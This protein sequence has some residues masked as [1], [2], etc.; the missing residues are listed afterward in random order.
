MGRFSHIKLLFV[1]FIAT[2]STFGALFEKP[3]DLSKADYDFIIVGGTC[4]APYI[5]TL[6]ILACLL[7]G[8]AGAVIANRLTENPNVSVLVLEAGNAYVGIDEIHSSLIQ[9]FSP[10]TLAL[11]LI[12][13]PSVHVSLLIRNMTGI[14]PPFRNLVLIIERSLLLADFSLVEAAPSVGV[15][16]AA[17]L[18]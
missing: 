4:W 13:Q 16:L 10:E 1:A 2:S 14:I 17:Q 11:S 12:S 6:F 18:K 9:N 8:T 7:G 5:E 15:F 3:Q